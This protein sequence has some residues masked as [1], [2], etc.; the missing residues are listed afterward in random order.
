MVKS[1][2]ER[3]TEAASSAAVTADHAERD[4]KAWNLPRASVQIAP[5]RRHRD[6]L[7][8]DDYRDLYYP[9]TRRHDFE[10]IVAYGDYKRS[11]NAPPKVATPENGFTPAGRVPLPAR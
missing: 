3:R 9:S 7:D 6:G 5:G 1:L 2:T 10:A 4:R 8:W 11:P